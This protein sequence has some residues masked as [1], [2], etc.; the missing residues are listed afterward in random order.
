M[1]INL[2]HQPE[3]VS[4]ETSPEVKKGKLGKE[5]PKAAAPGGKP[6]PP[7]KVHTA[8]P[9]GVPGAPKAPKA[10]GAA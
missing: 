4:T 8:K 3:E 2:N 10:P 6:T 1:L 9:A 7:P 5:E